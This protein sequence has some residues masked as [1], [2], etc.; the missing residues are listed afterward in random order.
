MRKEAIALLLVVVIVAAFWFFTRPNEEEV[1]CPSTCKYGCILGT[2]QCRE[3]PPL[4]CPSTCKLGCKP[5]TDECVQE[6]VVLKTKSVVE[7]GVL[8]ANSTMISNVSSD[9]TC[10]VIGTDNTTLDCGWHK[11]T[12]RKAAESYAI[13]IKNRNNVTIKNC[14]IEDYSS[15]ISIDSSSNV[16]LSNIMVE[17]STGSGISVIS[18]ADVYIE[19]VS[20]SKNTIAGVDLVSSSSIILSR[21]SLFNNY[22]GVSAKNSNFSEFF[23]NTICSNNFTDVDCENSGILGEKENSCGESQCSI[24]CIPCDPPLPG[25]VNSSEIPEE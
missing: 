7:C 3:P 14:I 1:K 13:R 23:Y 4:V 20:S 5:G 21:N 25:H 9:S 24:E 16:H 8:T 10:F 15:G 11:I 18:S 6:V 2:A 12:G 22:I 17:D 19:K